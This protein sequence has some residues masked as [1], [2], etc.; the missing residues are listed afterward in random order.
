MTIGQKR[1]SKKP[2]AGVGKMTSTRKP[3]GTPKSVVVAF[4][5][6]N[7]V[8]AKR[9]KRPRG[10]RDQSRKTEKCQRV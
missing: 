1:R 8:M 10:T 2:R 5:R 7:T 9:K 6:T 4:L 3:K